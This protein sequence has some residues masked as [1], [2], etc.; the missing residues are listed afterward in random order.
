MSGVE[1]RPKELTIRTEQAGDAVRLT[2]QDA[3]MGIQPEALGRLFE[4]FYTTKDG[5]MGIGPFISRSIIESHHGR[6]WAAPNDGPGN[7]GGAG[8]LL[9]TVVSTARNWY[10]AA[11]L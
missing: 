9:L 4:P 10:K 8:V 3:G 2:V 7:T 5:G 11:N 1:G 6:I